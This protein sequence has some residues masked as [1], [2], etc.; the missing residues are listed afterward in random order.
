[1]RGHLFFDLDG[2]LTDPKPGIVGCLRHALVSLGVAAPPDEKLASC[3]GP[4][5][6]DSLRSILG[7]GR[8][9]LLPKAL[10]LYRE[11][12]GVMGMFENRVYP[13]I[14]EALEA[15]AT[16]GWRLWVVTSKPVVFAKPILDHF[17][18]TR[19]FERVHGAELSGARAD[20]RDLIAHV[21]RTEGMLPEHA[22]MVGDR[23]HDVVGARANEVRAHGVL[24]GYGS[25]DELVNAG[26]D[27]VHESVRDL[28]SA[29]TE[30]SDAPHT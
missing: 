30:D 19:H 22:I 14:P 23:S 11:R 4:P 28:V 29:L 26:A 24:W 25:R 2:T 20:K 17:Q 15:L 10:E 3:I 1:M 8:V 13:G 21:L 9:A 7:P 18:L 27:P 12:F 5:L 6:H 16:V